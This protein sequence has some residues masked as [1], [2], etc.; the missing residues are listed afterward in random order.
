MCLLFCLKKHK[1]TTSITCVTLNSR[2]M[3]LF[4]TSNKYNEINNRGNTQ[5]WILTELDTGSVLTIQ[6]YTWKITMHFEHSA[7]I[8]E[9]QLKTKITAMKYQISYNNYVFG[10]GT[11]RCNNLKLFCVCQTDNITAY[12]YFRPPWFLL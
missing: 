6:K 12:C 2:N 1:R 4:D 10:N 11:Y 8:L 7:L 5:I 3:L 9:A